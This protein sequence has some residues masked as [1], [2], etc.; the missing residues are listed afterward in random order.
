MKN[1]YFNLIDLLKSKYS[2]EQANHIFRY[3]FEFVT[4]KDFA[5]F[6]IEQ[7]LE[8]NV[9]IELQNLINIHINKDK[10]IQYILG[11]IDFIDSK[12]LVESPILIPRPETEE[13]VFNLLNEFKF[14]QNEKLKIVEVGTGSGCIAIALAKFFKNSEIFALDI[15]QKALDLA[16]KNA[17]LNEVKNIKFIKSDVFSNFNE[18]VDFIISN[19]P[20]ISDEQYNNLD[21]SVKNWEDK[22]ALTTEHDGLFIIKKIIENSKL[23][24]SD[25]YLEFPKIILEIGFDQAKKVSE[26]FEQNNFKS[27]VLK[28]YAGQDRVCLGYRA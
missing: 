10:P 13:W 17:D 2:Q 11:E 4:K 23:I 18:K 14:I 12:I 15:N 20:Y 16:K 28:D 3:L 8:D 21:L 1:N 24:L 19:P 27:T 7:T 22:L 9:L 6:L 26:I 5:H 25:K